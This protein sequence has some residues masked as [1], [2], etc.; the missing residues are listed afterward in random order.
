MAGLLALVGGLGLAGTMSLNVL[1][2]TREI[3]VLR[4][5]GASNGAV[6]KVV[7][8]EGVVVGLISWILG[9]LVAFPFGH[10]LV[11][12]VGVA[13]LQTQMDVR[14]SALGVGLW[15]ALIYAIYAR[16]LVPGLRTL[17]EGE[18]DVHLFTPVEVVG[19]G[20]E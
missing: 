11:N 14:F 5:L 1:E 18:R 2:R 12:A 3:G 7:L 9:T 15:L 6:R 10:A 4:A 20:T 19:S 16:D 8:F 13:M 17:G